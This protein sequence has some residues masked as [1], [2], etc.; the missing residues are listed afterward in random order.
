MKKGL[1]LLIA[2]LATSVAYGETTDQSAQASL[3]DGEGKFNW[4]MGD[5]TQEAKYLKNATDGKTTGQKVELT[6][7]KGSVKVGEKLRFDYDLDKDIY[8][9]KDG[10]KTH[11]GLDTSYGVS[12]DSG[13]YN[14]WNFE[15]YLGMEWDAKDDIPS[16]S[17]SNKRKLRRSNEKYY[18]A[19]R[20]NKQ[21]SDMVWFQFDPRLYKDAMN[22]DIYGDVRFQFDTD[23]GGGWTN[24]TEIYNTFGKDDADYQLDLENYLKYTKN[25]DNGLYA[26]AELGAEF[27]N[28]ANSNKDNE[29]NLFISP[30][31]GYN[32]KMGEHFT[33]TPYAGYKAA[34]HFGSGV[35]SANDNSSEFRAGLKAKTKF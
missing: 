12:I 34:A 28:L 29:S 35:T 10:N 11:D 8:M 15:N 1:L 25:W 30:E 24:W 7:A 23:L 18:W 26:S 33:L 22:G 14:G 13:S 5:V 21:L 27:Y 32:A 19:A 6:M 3:E 17:S 4:E 16:G 31:V 2:A 20:A 9:D